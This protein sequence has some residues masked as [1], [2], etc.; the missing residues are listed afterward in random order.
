MN[1]LI[2]I[3]GWLSLG[4]S[5]VEP[6]EL[7][8]L[9]ESID[10]EGVLVA[11]LIV[12]AAWVVNR[13]VGDS[14]ERLGEGAAKR[15]LL[16]KRLA[17]LA[18]LAIFLL[19]FYL[20]AITLLEGRQ[21]LL[22]G[23]GGTIAV[24]AGLALE[25]TV[26]SLFAGFL[27]L[28]D[29]PFQVGDR[30]RFGNTYGEVVDIGL[31]SVRIDT[32]SDDEV[33]V[34]NNRFLSDTVTSANA[35]SLDMMVVVGFN[36]AI[37]EDAD[38]AKRLVYETCVT[39]RFIYLEESVSMNVREIETDAGLAARIIC[40]AYIIDARHEMDYVNDVTDRVKYAFRRHGIERP[41]QQEYVVPTG[42][43]PEVNG[44]N[45]QTRSTIAD[46]PSGD[47]SRP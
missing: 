9:L 11:G 35:G 42:D 2:P 6:R 47:G 12:L 31:L 8:K 16:T 32:L 22:I 15:R 30:I 39:S 38:L 45:G 41:Y 27:I 28:V 17:T 40:K 23:L 36:V 26:S 3:F 13:L 18:R 44:S 33:A 21:K 24:A 19:A 20:V 43:T 5:A 7:V 1:S 4:Q 37:T 46:A 34:P 25:D 29:Q 10:L 14:L